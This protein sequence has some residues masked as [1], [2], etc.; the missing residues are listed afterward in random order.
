VSLEKA[1][2][3]IQTEGRRDIAKGRSP[4]ELEVL[5]RIC[6]I[7]LDLD[8]VMLH[9]GAKAGRGGEQPDL[10]FGRKKQERKTPILFCGI[11]LRPKES[12]WARRTP[13]PE[14]DTVRLYL[15][16]NEAGANRSEWGYMFQDDDSVK[17]DAEWRF[18]ELNDRM[19]ISG[20]E[21]LD[22]IEDAY[23][24]VVGI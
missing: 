20:D 5:D 18:I 14:A 16:L 21:I 9:Q 13:V 17:P 23:F 6:R 2:N 19:D 24:E 10:M 12:V 3:W 11:V 1:R 7:G 8:G 22:L 4:R 15:K